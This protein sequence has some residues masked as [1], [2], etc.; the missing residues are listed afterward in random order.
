M[1]P[2]D[3]VWFCFLLAVWLAGAVW[4]ASQTSF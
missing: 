2:L 3:V 4:Y 1:K